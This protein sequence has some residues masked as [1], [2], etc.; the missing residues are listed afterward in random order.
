VAS[1]GKNE[2]LPFSTP[3]MQCCT[4]SYSEPIKNNNHLYFDWMGGGGVWIALFSNVFPNEDS[5]STILLLVVAIT[6]T[7]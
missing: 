4:C 7:F 3:S 1:K 6:N 2:A 5:V